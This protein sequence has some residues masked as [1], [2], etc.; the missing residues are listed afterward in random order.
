VDSQCFIFN[1][2][3]VA[4]VNPAFQILPNADLRRS[5]SDHIRNHVKKLPFYGTS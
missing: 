1:P 4:D 3:L 2:D 5:G